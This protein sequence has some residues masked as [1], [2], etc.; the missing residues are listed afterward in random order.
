[1][2]HSAIKYL[3]T[4]KETKP[5]VIKW[6]L[7]LQ[8]FDVDIKDKEGGQNQVANHLSR[9]LQT[10]DGVPLMETFPDEYLYSI[11]TTKMG[12][13]WYADLVYYLAI[14]ELPKEIEAYHKNKLVRESK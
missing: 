4:K 14:R 12:K 13:P 9:I 2:D 1:M 6:I 3:M 10:D 8:E 5:R 7:L 11:H